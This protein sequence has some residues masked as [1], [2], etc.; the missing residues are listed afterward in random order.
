MGWKAQHVGGSVYT[1]M[2]GDN[3]WVTQKQLLRETLGRLWR[4]LS[5]VNI[6]K[7]RAAQNVLL[8][9]ETFSVPQVHGVRWQRLLQH[10]RQWGWEHRAGTPAGQTHRAALGE[11]KLQNTQGKGVKRVLQ[12]SSAALPCAPGAGRGCWHLGRPSAF[13]GKRGQARGGCCHLMLAQLQLCRAGRQRGTARLVPLPHL[14]QQQE[15]QE[16]CE[17]TGRERERE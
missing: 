11:P 17:M 5:C 6:N 1:Q 9:Q 15:I 10:C 14:K 8:Q 16:L 7:I 12:R 2:P 4:Q 13:Q 3:S